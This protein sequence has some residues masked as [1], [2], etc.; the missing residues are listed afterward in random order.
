MFILHNSQLLK[1]HFYNNYKY[2]EVEK[3]NDMLKTSELLNK[4][5]ENT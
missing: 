3:V 1:F 4:K 2:L 5:V